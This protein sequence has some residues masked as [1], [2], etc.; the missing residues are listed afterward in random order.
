MMFFCFFFKLP[1]F[2]FQKCSRDLKTIS[3]CQLDA[4]A[5]EAQMSVSLISTLRSI[6]PVYPFSFGASISCMKTSAADAMA[7]ILL[8]ERSWSEFDGCRSSIFFV[9]GAVYLGGVQI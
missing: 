7:Q 5:V 1:S 9:W 6:P 4:E 3:K 8:E 2:A